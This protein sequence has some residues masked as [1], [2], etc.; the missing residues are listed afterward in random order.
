M[1]AHQIMTRKVVTVRP[2]ASIVEAANLMLTHHVSGL[3][4]VDGAGSLVGIVT[5]GDFLRRAETGTQRKRSALL[6]FLVGPGRAGADYVAEHGRRVKEVMTCNPLTVEEDATLDDIVHLMEKN[7]VKRLPVMRQQ[8]MVGIVSRANLLRAVASLAREVP[9]PTATDQRIRDHILDVV[10]NAPWRPAGFD[11]TV[12]NGVVDLHGIIV[13]EHS[14]Q[15]A[16][17][18]AENVAGVAAVHDHLCWVDTYSGFYLELDEDRKA[19]GVS[20]A[21]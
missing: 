1:R 7:N 4:V 17:V 14:R 12:R 8:A 9:D 21:S 3:P 18:A 5:E 6:E 13:D 20:Q 16:I 15:A 19:A 11:A 2:D 10:A